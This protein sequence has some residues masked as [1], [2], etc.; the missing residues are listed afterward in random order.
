MGQTYL[1]KNKEILIIMTTN[2]TS[3]N[4]NTNKNKNTN[5]NYEKLG[6]TLVQQS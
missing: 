5:N 3:N 6:H 4:T 2:N 1:F